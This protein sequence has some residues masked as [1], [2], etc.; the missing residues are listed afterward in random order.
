MSI[1]VFGYVL[2]ILIMK[3]KFFFACLAFLILLLSAQGC[4]S[5]S[6]S[7]IK[8]MDSFSISSE[9]FT[10]YPG[11]L[12]KEMAEI[13]MGRGLFFAS[14]LSNPE[15]R[16][17]ELTALLAGLA[18]DTSL[19]EK[20]D[21]SMEILGKYQRALKILAGSARWQDV[22]VEFRSLGRNIDSLIERYNSLE[23]AE[24]LPLG[25][26][27]LAGRVVGTVAESIN[28]RN[29]LNAVKG[30]VS[31]AD[32]LVTSLVS[33]LSAILSSPAVMALIQNEDR[34]LDLNYI[35]YVKAGLSDDRGYLE[36]RRR[37]E[38][39]KKMRANTVT[40]AKRLAN[41]HSKIV[42]GLADKKKIDEV[43]EELLA[44]ERE[45]LTLRKIIG[46]I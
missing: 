30:F 6:K 23:I 33:D 8:A 21:L 4:A 43:F 41:S 32:T 44:L 29:Q 15:L 7:Q 18:N 27:K 14:S 16:V 2:E 31:A 35:S 17:E 36:L 13:R 38:A 10:Q 5:L 19:A 40:A 1:F 45:V 11:L 39:L 20:T 46:D 42:A 22:G 24:S 34:G 28:K 9:E 26:G 3:N 25:V 37:V 12:F